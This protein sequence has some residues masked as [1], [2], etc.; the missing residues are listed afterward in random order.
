MKEFQITNQFDETRIVGTLTLDEK[1]LERLKL[2]PEQCITFSFAGDHYLD[3]EGG[4]PIEPWTVIGAALIP[5]SNLPRER[6]K[7]MKR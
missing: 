3:I 5:N 2:Y 4:K 1:T 7:D 6:Y